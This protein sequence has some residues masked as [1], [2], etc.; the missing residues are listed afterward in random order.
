MQQVADANLKEEVFHNQLT[1]KETL[2]RMQVR[3][4]TI[5][6]RRKS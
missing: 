3:F 5:F 6:Y 1:T 2:S 4:T